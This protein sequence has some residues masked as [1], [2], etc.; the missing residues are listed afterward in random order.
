[1]ALEMSSYHYLRRNN[2]NF[3]QTFLENKRRGYDNHNIKIWYEHY[4]K[5]KW[6][7]VSFI[8]NPKEILASQNQQCKK[9]TVI[10]D[11]VG[12]MPA[13]QSWDYIYISQYNSPY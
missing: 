3:T 1:M 10:Y 13:M 7:A 8:N 11:E 6:Q 5:G 12:F 4:K 9:R 2:C